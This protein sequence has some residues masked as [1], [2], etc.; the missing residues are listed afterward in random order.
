MKMSASLQKSTKRTNIDHNNRTKKRLPPHIDQTRLQENKY[1]IQENIRD[2]YA[3]EFDVSLKKYNDKQKR[4]DRK[5]DN[6]YKHIQSSKKTATQQEMILQIGDK[7]D[8][9]N[10]HNWEFANEVLEDWF[11]NFEKRNPNLKVYNA[12]IHNDEA[13]PHLHINFVPVASGYER[14][15]EKQVAFDRAIKQQDPSLDSNRPFDDWR[16]KEVAVLEQLMNE[17]GVDRKLVGKNEYKDVNEYKQKKDKLRE[18]EIKVENEIKKFDV[19]TDKP[20]QKNGI[21]PIVAIGKGNKPIPKVELKKTMFGGY[22]VEREQ[23]E[24]L[25][26]YT[27]HLKHE[28]SDLQDELDESKEN[29]QKLRKSYLNDRRM[30]NKLVEDGIVLERQKMARERFNYDKTIGYLSSELKTMES[31]NKELKREISVLQQWKHRAISFMEKIYVYDKFKKVFYRM[32]KSF[33]NEMER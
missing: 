25:K 33:N 10:P 31:E 3:R 14:G 21:E 24:S 20:K 18:L 5:I 23:V 17:R 11:N 6:Y 29:Y 7:D 9:D 16:E 32:K 2:I 15:L 30:I 26:D 1:L 22:S 27:M 8:F 4:K 28:N 12:V 19:L 13:S